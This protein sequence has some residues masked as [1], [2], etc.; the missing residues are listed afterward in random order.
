MIDEK[1]LK[2]ARAIAYKMWNK[3]LKA[4]YTRE[5]IEAEAYYGLVH[6][7]QSYDSTKGVK[8]TSYAYPCIKGRIINLARLD[9][10]YY[11]NKENVER[12]HL[13]IDYSYENTTL[14]DFLAIEC[15]EIETIE[16]NDTLKPIYKLDRG[17]LEPLVAYYIED[18]TQQEIANMMGLSVNAVNNR[19][20]RAK[21][22]LREVITIWEADKKEI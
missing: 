13:S 7:L 11:N 18:F 5:E 3:G 22:K 4:R 2:M 10:Y 12:K 16:I 6:A 14:N 9:K 19:I 1:S 20:M 17:L 8:F 15:K 21:Y